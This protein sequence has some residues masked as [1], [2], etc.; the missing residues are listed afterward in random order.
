MKATWIKN[1]N[2]NKIV[3]KFEEIKIVRDDGTVTFEG[4]GFDD[5]FA[6]LN[7]MIILRSDIP[8]IEK[9]R[10]VRDAIF[11]AGAAGKITANKLLN[12]TEKLQS[13]YLAK[14]LKKYKLVTSLSVS[15]NSRLK[16]LRINDCTISF[17]P[18]LNALLTSESEKIK[19]HAARGLFGELPTNYATV[20]IT[21]QAKS[22]NAAAEKAID[23]I[24]LIRGIWNLFYNKGRV[25]RH[26]GGK[27]KPVN[28]FVL[29]PLHTLHLANGK[30]ATSDWWY[31][32]DYRAPLDTHDLTKEDVHNPSKKLKNMYKFQDK[33][34]KHLEQCNYKSD[35]EDAIIKY[36]HA[37]DFINRENTFLRLWSVL[38]LL[39][40]TRPN[41][42]HNVT[43]KRVSFLFKDREY[44]LQILNHLKDHRNRAVHAGSGSHNIETL[45]FQLKRYV[46]AL[47]YFHIFNK[48]SFKNLEAAAHF[49]DLPSDP[50]TLESRIQMMCNAKKLFEQP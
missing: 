8:Q 33:V 27:P 7:S 34:R 45:M 1:Y 5:C 40:N 26:F 42:S 3:K 36:T 22:T 14:P 44:T 15:C 24:D 50:E 38:E 46:E 19:K 25:T 37:L 12:E 2:P 20:V 35:I 49:L 6:V 28:K 23:S 11:R 30:C 9:S 48:Y 18:H 43:V 41:E 13:A 29:G 31:E 4:S 47:L 39:T 17:N 16:R 10:I 21:L 32:S